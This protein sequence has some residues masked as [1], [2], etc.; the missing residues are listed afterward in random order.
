MAA[1]KLDQQVTAR[2]R[3]ELGEYF[4]DSDGVFGLKAKDWSA[5]VLGGGCD[6]E[7]AVLNRHRLASEPGTK[8]IERFREIRA[9]LMML[10]A[11]HVNT[12]F[13]VFGPV[14]W[15]HQLDEGFG[16]G[17]GQRVV[18]RLGDLCGV[19]LL[20][21]QVEQGFA[22]WQ[23][24]KKAEKPA[25]KL[26]VVR[27]LEDDKALRRRVARGRTL[28]SDDT[29]TKGL[30]AH[31]LDEAARELGLER[32]VK[33]LRAFR[34]TKTETPSTRPLWER[35]PKVG[36]SPGGW[37]V[38]LCTKKQGISKPA[39][40]VQKAAERLFAEAVAVYVAARGWK[41][42]ERSPRVLGCILPLQPV[43][44]TAS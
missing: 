5:Q 41:P 34:A 37:L 24:E 28:V 30:S 8:R 7:S 15:L 26:I 42:S 2:V 9:V 17:M 36:E 39:V 16:K 10:R 21:E 1:A 3:A 40:Q 27:D 11:L 38:D 12:L 13:A 4:A 43:M 44:G 29:S 25:G 35:R 22:K 18:A 31:E 23:A 19:A 32:E 14:D 33:A 20:T 6:R